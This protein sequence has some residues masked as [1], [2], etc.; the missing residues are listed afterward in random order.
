M[1][2][3]IFIQTNLES[4]IPA[5]V[6]LYSFKKY[7]P[8]WDVKIL[9]MDKDF[10]NFNIH[11]G[12][13]FYRNVPSNK[14]EES[15]R[16][17]GEKKREILGKCVWYKDSLQNFFP[18]RFL[19]P[20]YVKYEGI[21]LL[22]ESDMFCLKSFDNLLDYLKENKKLSAV[23]QTGGPGKDL[24]ASSVLLFEAS[25]LKEWSFKK[26]SKFMFK[27]K[28][29]F[30]D[31]MYL[32]DMYQKNEVNILPLKYNDFNN[33]DKETI[34]THMINTV[35]QPWKTGLEY[36]DDKLHNSK[37]SNESKDKKKF[38]KSQNPIIEK[39]FI[40]LAKEALVKGFLTIND[41]NHNINKGYIRKDLKE[42]IRL[43]LKKDADKKII[44]YGKIPKN[45]LLHI[46]YE[47]K[48]TGHNGQDKFVSKIFKNKKSFFVELGG[49]DGLR[50]SNTF[51]LESILGWD[52]LLV[53]S[54][55]IFSKSCEMKRKCKCVCE[56][57]YS[58]ESILKFNINPNEGGTSGLEDLALKVAI[59]KKTSTYYTLTKTL[60]QIFKENNVPK[61]IGYLSLDIEGSEY[62]ALKKFPFNKYN[63]HLI[64]FEDHDENKYHLNLK[65]LLKKNNYKFLCKI[66]IDS[67]YIKNETLE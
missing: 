29:D 56:T 8:D 20:E 49:D 34:I 35:S 62:H 9:Y 32:R 21:C 47:K 44:K 10:I 60:E 50:K 43:E 3:T 30:N 61:D 31:L 51:G 23:M 45:L 46:P 65:P 59:E 13:T 37:K 66:S 6:S 2:N 41:I 57:I 15:E 38:L 26:L 18:M 58:K 17:I 54:R 42:L 4:K 53:E 14:I 36:S 48:W 33:I 28:K 67:F 39:K 1:K 12:K 5:L 64:S 19:I 11:D 22:V 55:P 27:K 52:G 7:N 25:K 63:I 40:E 16:I 24:P